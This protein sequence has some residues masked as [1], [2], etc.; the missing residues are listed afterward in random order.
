MNITKLLPKFSG[1][2]YSIL[3][4]TTKY[5]NCL[6]TIS[7]PQIINYGEKYYVGYELS[8]FKTR[9]KN[10]GFLKY[11]S[12]ELGWMKSVKKIYCKKFLLKV[13]ETTVF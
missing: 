1:E 6:V 12:E 9:I 10:E 8:K 2:F 5:L 13:P 4:I 11:L 7:L 3:K